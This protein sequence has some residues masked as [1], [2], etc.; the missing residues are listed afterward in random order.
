MPDGS[1][2][3]GERERLSIIFGALTVLMLAAL[4]QT[5]VS[6][7]LPTIGAALGDVEYLSWVV[8]AYFLTSTAV[9]PL[10]G[11]LADLR[12]RRPTL[13]AAVGIFSLGSVLCAVA[14][15]MTLL[16]V[17][18][19]VQGL[20]GGGL[21]SLVQ[22]VIGDVV[23]PRERGRFMGWISLVWATASVSGPVIGGV[24]AQH[25]HWSLIFWINL[26]VAAVAVAMIH[27][28]MRHLPDVHRPQRL[29][30]YGAVLIVG[31]TVALMLALTWGGARMPWSSP[32]ILALAA[33]FA[34][35]FGLF[36]VHMIRVED[37]LIP[38]SVFR[39]PVVAVTTS[40]M[41]F[42]MGSWL[43]L[44][45]WVPI[46]LEQAHGFGAANA[47][48]G[49]IALTLGTVTGANFGGRALMR[50][51]HYKRLVLAGSAVG[52]LADAALAAG[53]PVL[54]FWAAEALLGIAGFG[55][56]ML[57]P[58]STVAVQ[59]AVE[60][61]DLG[62]ATA[63]HAFF[64]SLGTV[65]VVAALGAIFLSSGLGA[66]IEGGAHL[67]TDPAHAVL[68]AETFRAIFAAAA[69]GQLIGLVIFLFLEER[70]LVGRAAPK[71]D[72]AA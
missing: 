32:T 1:P 66:A 24:F 44:T 33:V 57:F 59:N 40:A 55:T 8:S 50:V 41:F 23:P 64:R 67:R 20:G 37:A 70:P 25:L 72:E 36:V 17:G 6:P 62:V 10:Y 42:V 29:D 39:N 60:R 13:Y 15:N 18:R 38:L 51:P 48:F 71:P 56:G 31:G 27:R 53:S 12:G 58:L 52:V 16:V 30:W 28:A 2:A 22:T 11:K 7:A 43:A 68:A 35:S 46:W 34:L 3:L 61:R 26:P 45:V 65:V 4:D 69:F 21:I 14:P 54:P 19:A 49:L 47:G 63:T 5:I 9:T